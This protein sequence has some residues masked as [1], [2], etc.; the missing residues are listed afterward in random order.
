M[1]RIPFALFGL[2]LLLGIA[3]A[4][5]AAPSAKGTGT[6]VTL[7]VSGLHCSASEQA[8]VT[9]VTKLGGVS[10]VKITRKP[11]RLTA[12]LDE[13]KTSLGAFVGAVESEPS[14]ANPGKNLGAKV[15]VT[16]AAKGQSAAVLAKALKGVA[17]VNGV[18]IDAKGTQ[19][20][21]FLAKDAKVTTADI[22]AALRAVHATA[23]FTAAPAPAAPAAKAGCSMMG[24]KG[25]KGGCSMMGGK[26]DK[27][28]CSMMGS[29]GCAM[30]DDA[31]AGGMK[32]CAMKGGA[33]A[34]GKDGCS[35]M[36]GGGS[37]PMM[38]GAQANAKPEVKGACKMMGGQETKA[39]GMAG[40]PMTSGKAAGGAS[41][42]MSGGSCTM[43]D[44]PAAK[45]G[46]C[47]MT[48]DAAKTDEKK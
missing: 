39:G 40:C 18:G 46:G 15:L 26:G 17:G 12:V 6:P 48:Q 30:M 29:G 11:D 38:G 3:A 20:A 35:M 28:G 47:P 8:L 9:R 22:A 43:G 37:C 42:D 19:A 2:L 31:K 44:K 16:L 14:M 41:C 21:L 10:Q 5:F 25:A 34:G 13:S 7:A 4:L 23:S 45:H 1:T 24:G 27:G 36:G 32:G 33:K